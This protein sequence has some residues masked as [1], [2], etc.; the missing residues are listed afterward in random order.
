VGRES[1]L[2]A[3]LALAEDNRR[4]GTGAVVFVT[5]EA[6]IGKSRLVQE[7]ADTAGE[8]GCPVVTARAVEASSV[9]LRLVS[10]V[11]T[12]ALGQ[13][14]G[15]V[16]AEPELD[17]FWPVLARVAPVA[18]HAPGAAFAVPVLAAGVLQLL[19]CLRRP[20]VVLE[21]VQ[22]A[23]A[24]S[25][26]VAE[27]WAD[28]AA[29]AG[30]VFAI[31]VRDD[32]QSPVLAL[33]RRLAGRGAASIA[34]L[35]RLTGEQSQA[36]AA[37]CLGGG[38]APGPDRGTVMR[39]AAMSD[40]LPLLV[41]G[42]AADAA[43]AGPVGLAPRS[44]ADIVRGRMASLS[45]G[46]RQVLQL[47]AV[48]GPVVAYEVLRWAVAGA[49]PP[50]GAASGAAVGG[51]VDERLVSALRAG[52]RV[53]LISRRDGGLA[54][55]HALVADAITG[56]LLP[57]ERARLCRLV[58][59]AVRAAHPEP[60]GPWVVLAADLFARAGEKRLAA[61]MLLDAGRGA[62]T[63]GP[64]PSAVT[65]LDRA[66]E[67]ASQISAAEARP[68]LLEVQHRLLEAL[69]ASGDSIRAA[70]VGEQIIAR[71]DDPLP[72]RPPGNDRESKMVSVCL[73]LARA[74]IGVS[75][76]RAAGY[77]RKARETA[78]CEERLTAQV[79]AVDAIVTLESSRPNHLAIAE[80]LA[81]RAAGPAEQH[82][83]DDTACEAYEVLGRCLRLRDLS[84]GEAAFT[85]QLELAQRSNHALL[86]VRALNELGTIDALRSLDG[87]RLN[88]ARSA[89]VA[90]GALSLAAQYDI[91]IV[92]VN[93]FTGHHSQAMKTAQDCENLARRLGLTALADTARVWQATV[94]AYRGRAREVTQLLAGISEHHAL[95]IEVAEWGLCRAMLALVTE[96]RAGALAAYARAD[97][98]A[99]RKAPLL[100]N[101]TGGPQLLLELVEGAPGPD[102]VAD[103]ASFDVR[104][105]RMHSGFC[106][107]VLAGRQGRPG[108]A[109]AA[110]ATGRDA[111]AVYALHG[112]LYLRLA[113][114]AALR[115]GWGDPVP[116]LMEA[117]AAFV[118]QGLP[119]LT[120]AC[121]GLLRA[122]GVT[123]G[124]SGMESERLVP[125][126][127][128]QAGVT[129]REHQI[130][131][132]V[133]ERLANREI[134]ARLHLS[135]RTVEN[136]VARLLAKLGARNR[137]ELGDQARLI[138]W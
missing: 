69:V 11:A 122:A 16:G 126:R 104:W 46:H 19:A 24:A 74:Q 86:R 89:A 110:L 52:E 127:L 129:A 3:C 17:P 132:L 67:V 123:I 87:H 128:R 7:L 39:L 138:E 31:T 26:E 107:A 20:L 83:L 95:D 97:E 44:F 99:R 85:R 70:G 133:G 1:E 135:V 117:E 48:V 60:D 93:L 75:D 27:Y 84:Q 80:E 25:L 45:T 112:P 57:P 78:G 121:R 38:S 64:L 72:T 43:S 101:V 71:L 2:A 130:L 137:A 102:S 41:E 103:P 65:L 29:A 62:L 76:Q 96:D 120:S 136:H 94:A 4:D 115:D 131:A 23:D 49:M 6:G 68:V 118:A 105:D 73:L 9:P 53:G 106:A 13:L 59:E 61:A 134:A 12:V 63:G 98:L 15:D 119:A 79:D 36:M 37:A 92:V 91:N 34:R 109:E 14:G 8:A 82:G 124:R 116:W 10:E 47:A 90:A 100:G 111:A 56:D 81:R 108:D 18:G 28:H 114:E 66:A 55:R 33:A 50:P 40:G 77:L 88:A 42:L 21:D 22:W 54:F 113:A 5:G 51:R 125:P 32:Q 35:H 30:V 58:A